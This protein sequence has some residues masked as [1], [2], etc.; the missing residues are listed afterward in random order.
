MGKQTGRG[1][2]SHA[3]KSARA[4]ASKEN[5]IANKASAV[6]TKKAKALAHA[7]AFDI[8]E[9]TVD[10]DILSDEDI[11]FLEEHAQYAQSIADFDVND[12]K[13]KTPKT[14]Q[15]A[16]AKSGAQHSDASD[17][18]DDLDME[19][20]EIVAE[21]SDD[22]DESEEDER[23][24]AVAAR[25]RSSH[26][27][28][29]ASRQP[30]TATASDS[31]SDNSDDDEIVQTLVEGDDDH[32]S[33]S[34]LDSDDD[35]LDGGSDS[36]SSALD[37]DLDVDVDE[38]PSDIESSDEE[39]AVDYDRISAAV[40]STRGGHDSSSSAAARRGA[41][42]AEAA[43]SDSLEQYERRPRA[44]PVEKAGRTKLPVKMTDGRILTLSDSSDDD[45]NDAND[46]KVDEEPIK[47]QPSKPMAPR[48]GAL[49][50]DDA[51]AQH[52]LERIAVNCQRIL[53][54]PESCI[55]LLVSVAE[56]LEYRGPAV[57]G[58]DAAQIRAVA[59]AS[60]GQVYL[61]LIPGYRIV[62]LTSA[63]KTEKVNKDVRKLRTF[64][65]T[66]LANY[67]RFLVSLDTEVKRRL[68]KS[69]SMRV[70][71]SDAAYV[72]V[73]LMCKL[74]TTHPHF[75][76]R[77]NIVNVLTKRTTREEFVPMIMD[78]LR[79]L[80]ARDE[81]GQVSSEAARLLAKVIK[82]SNFSV[83]PSVLQVLTHLRL[84][85]ELTLEDLLKKGAKR[86]AA[87]EKA[88]A[89]A[90]KNPSRKTKDLY[91]NKKQRKASKHTKEVLEELKE[92][93]AVVD[94]EDRKK[95]H[96]ITLEHVFLIYFRILKTAALS[97]L[98]P[99]ALEGLGVFAH[100]IS[101]EYFD[102]L[103]SVFKK[104]LASKEVAA[105]SKLSII[106]T[107][108]RVLSGQGQVLQLDMAD[109]Y[110][111]CYTV[112]GELAREPLPGDSM[113]LRQALD[114]LDEILRRKAA[115]PVVAALF[116]R[117]VALAAH[118]D[119]PGAAMACLASAAAMH[120]KFP[121]LAR[122]LD[123]PADRASIG[124]HD[125]WAVDPQLA[126]AL[127]AAP[128]E[129]AVCAAMHWHPDVRAAAR[130]VAR[131]MDP[132]RRSTAANSQHER[133][134]EW[135][136]CLDRWAWQS[137]AR[138]VPDLDEVNARQATSKAGKAMARK[139]ARAETEDGED[140][141]EDGE[142]EVELVPHGHDA[143]DRE[144]GRGGSRG[145]SRGRGGGRGRGGN[146]GGSRGGRGGGGDRGGF[147][148]G[149][150]SRGGF[151]RGGGSSDRGGYSRGGGS[152]DRGSSSSDRGGFSRG[153]S[154]RGGFSRGGGESSGDRGGYSRGGYSRGGGSGGDRSSSSSSTY[155]RGGGGGRGGY[156]RGG[157]DSSSRGGR[158]RS[159]YEPAAKR[160]R[161]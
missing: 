103:F 99:T 42:V 69:G 146:R 27:Q 29:L 109:F 43:A 84:K 89:N 22:D 106:S 24:S 53:D 63:Q 98:M 147:S 78:C 124:S 92:A 65:Q 111:A 133:I 108:N 19:D 37:S 60:L 152:S 122:V 30:T 141:Q 47:V 161:V 55:G 16:Y 139:R 25:V 41:K 128:Y 118:V 26:P 95:H 93:E 102:S 150:S 135:R 11:K 31:D 130:A 21:S 114:V 113:R 143:P 10:T 81:E 131:A 36:D 66:L 70:R 96:R 127:A 67:R 117:L 1:G 80:F 138:F 28:K 33:D 79:E 12:L 20:A 144:G 17:D 62:E 35:S 8:P 72:A 158:G 75:N 137:T 123:P 82:A 40:A 129:L 71:E 32:G 120:A 121:A 3:K 50:D 110:T 49:E 153:G 7:T 85:Y 38:I 57:S 104:L 51:S 159:S 132:V 105:E 74:L 58:I 9:S 18:S 119:D 136:E 101:I 2:G 142:Q 68:S 125:P 13:K 151:S 73:H 14:K 154:S 86:L 5:R 115:L 64:E 23:A 112:L 88:V 45:T 34:D 6:A 94:L 59:L 39:A 116:T 76:F 15:P 54:D 48:R 87:K 145:G 44:A 52:P 157:G 149:G 140:D 77:T 156:S 160:P 4:I 155:S 97:P 100:L 126:H 148:R 61:D 46:I 107:A 91:I 83:D 134:M 90:V 56:W